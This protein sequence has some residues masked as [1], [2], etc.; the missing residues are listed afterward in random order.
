VG[1]GGLVTWPSNSFSSALG[2]IEWEMD[3]D[4]G[5]VIGR[6]SGLGATVDSSWPRLAAV[7]AV[8]VVS[9]L[10]EFWSGFP[11][12]QVQTLESCLLNAISKC[13]E[14]KY[15]RKLCNYGILSC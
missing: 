15:Y 14:K 4:V 10:A 7:L 5:M 8:V 1:L 12:V 9:V 11:A 6:G 2:V 13:T 3:V